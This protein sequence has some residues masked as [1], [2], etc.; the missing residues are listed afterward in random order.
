MSTRPATILVIDDDPGFLKESEAQLTAAGFDV[1]LALMGSQARIIISAHG[2]GLDLALVDIVMPDESGLDVIRSV[3]RI[4]P[5]LRVIAITRHATPTVVE[6][7][8]HFGAVATLTKPI[9]P[10]WIEVI[11]RAL[12]E[13]PSINTGR[14]TA[15]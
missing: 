7:A 2:N 1:L 4:A 13:P 5:D 6:T 8:R 15:T 11:R 12:R 9:G 14:A 3:R 10:E